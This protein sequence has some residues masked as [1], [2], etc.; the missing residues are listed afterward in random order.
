MSAKVFTKEELANMTPISMPKAYQR[1][2]QKP[3][4]VST[5]FTSLEDAIEYAAGESS[6]GDISYAGQILS[7]IDA[8]GETVD[9][10]KIDYDGSLVKIGEGSSKCLS[11][12][13]YTDALSLA[14]ENNIGGIINVISAETIS[15]NTYTEGLYIVTGNGVI[16]KLGVTSASGDVAGDIEQLKGKVNT[17]EQLAESMYWLTDEDDNEE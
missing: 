2:S 10:Y 9:I 11:A 17:L 4:D 3:L 15:A 16:S 13:T 7:V 8:S 1:S 14:T 5:I 6:Y 12:E